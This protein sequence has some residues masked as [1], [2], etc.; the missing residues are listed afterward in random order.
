MPP[1]FIIFPRNVPGL[2]RRF[3]Q[4]VF[5]INILIKTIDKNDN[6]LFISILFYVH[7]TKY[8][9][10]K[11][12]FCNGVVLDKQQCHRSFGDWLQAILD[13]SQSLHSLDIDISSF[14]CLCALTLITGNIVFILYIQFVPFLTTIKILILLH[15][16]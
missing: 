15:Q 6:N 5:L 8:T 16:I 4:S 12:I 14:S 3:S 1:A 7:R 9:D 13:F 2:G 11:L 10:T